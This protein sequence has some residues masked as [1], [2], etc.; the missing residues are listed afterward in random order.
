MP[1]IQ[2]KKPPISA[3]EK[4]K[5]RKLRSKVDYLRE[6]LRLPLIDGLGKMSSTD[7]SKLLRKLKEDV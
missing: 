6:Q 7:L 3:D 4:I 1:I 2:L 5:R